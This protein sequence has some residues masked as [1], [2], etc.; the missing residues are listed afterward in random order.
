M[1]SSSGP[2]HLSPDDMLPSYAHHA[3]FAVKVALL[4][5]GFVLFCACAVRFIPG[6]RTILVFAYNCFLQPI[7][8]VANQGERLDRFYQNQASGT[9]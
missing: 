2:I 5:G 7:G 1:V 6:V 8:K 3:P 9:L 4:V